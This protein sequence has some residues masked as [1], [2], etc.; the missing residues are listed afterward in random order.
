MKDESREAGLLLLDCDESQE[1]HR[2]VVRER[3]WMVDGVES[4][5]R[6]ESNADVCD[7]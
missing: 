4:G 2:C 1:L 6:P 5:W 3:R 7:Y